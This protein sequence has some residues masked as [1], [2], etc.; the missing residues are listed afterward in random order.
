M[1]ISGVQAEVSSW[2]GIEDGKRVGQIDLLID[3]RD[4]VINLCEMKYSLSAYDI[5]PS[6]MAHLNERIE[7]FRKMTKTRKAIHLTFVTVNG[8][9]HNAQW[10]MV[11]NEVTADDLFK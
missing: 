10:G 2:I 4:E 8:I 6:Y 3:R 1:G 11:Q 5:T 7:I 9:K